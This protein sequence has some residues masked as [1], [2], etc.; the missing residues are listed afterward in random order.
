[1]RLQEDNGLQVGSRD[2]VAGNDRLLER[3]NL[4]GAQVGVEVGL[5]LGEIDDGAIGTVAS[6]GLVS[7]S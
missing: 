3:D 6:V 2:V 1:M 4:V 5:D 7:K